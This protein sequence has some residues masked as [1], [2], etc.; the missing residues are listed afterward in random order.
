MV[1]RHT[2]K[3]DTRAPV[4]NFGSVRILSPDLNLMHVRYR[5]ETGRYRTPQIRLFTL[6]SRAA[7]LL[8]VLAMMPSASFRSR[9]WVLAEFGKRPLKF[10]GKTGPN[11][12]G[13]GSPKLRLR[14]I[15][16]PSSARPR[17]YEVRSVRTSPF[18][19]TEKSVPVG[20]VLL[21][22]NGDNGGETGIRTLET[23]SRLHTFQACAFDH[24]ATSPTRIV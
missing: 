15:L 8:R 14:A 22:R 21:V 13:R 1:K 7:R 17:V 18:E 3:A 24:S 9:F 6:A 23:V 12:S 11:R 19:N 20:A 16:S 10:N 4:P 5:R 2:A